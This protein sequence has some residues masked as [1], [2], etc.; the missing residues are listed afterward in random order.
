MSIVIGHFKVFISDFMSMGI[1]HP[2]RKVHYVEHIKVL[3]LG[4]IMTINT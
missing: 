3:K 4:L 2:T 1:K